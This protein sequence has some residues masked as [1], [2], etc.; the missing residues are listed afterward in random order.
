[1]LSAM[2]GHSFKHTERPAKAAVVPDPDP[3]FTLVPGNLFPVPIHPPRR[4]IPNTIVKITCLVFMNLFLQIRN[5]TGS[6]L[7]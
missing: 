3:G 6:V 4:M 7:C 2:A 5:K 1:M